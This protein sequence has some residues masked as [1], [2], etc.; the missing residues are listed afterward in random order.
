[1]AIS[2]GTYDNFTS[3]YSEEMPELRYAGFIT[4]VAVWV[5]LGITLCGMM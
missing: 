1:M 3:S 5:I 2:N 4:S